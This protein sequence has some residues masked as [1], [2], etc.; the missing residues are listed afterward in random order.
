MVVKT[1]IIYLQKDKFQIFSPNLGSIVEFRF[2]P[3]IVRDLDIINSTLLENLI[4][5][6]VTN[7][8]IAPSN[9]V[10][11][12][13]DNAYFIKDIFATSPEQKTPKTTNSLA[14]ANE[15]LQKQADEFIEHVPFDNVV[16]KTLPLKNGIK[17]CAT[18]KDFYEAFV[19]A[20]EHL[21]FTTESVIPGLVLGNGLSA[22]P[23]LDQGI[24]NL[25]VQRANT[26]KQY[27]LLH[28]QVFQPPAKLETEDTDEVELD[29][30][31]TKKPDKKRLVALTGIFGSLLFVLVIVYVQSQA[32]VTP[33]QQP[34]QASNPP[35]T[36]LP[37]INQVVVS[38]TTAPVVSPSD[39]QTQALTVQIVNAASTSVAAKN[40]SE[41]LSQYTFKNILLQTQSPV[42]SAATIVSF[43]PNVTQ[44]VRNLILDE[45]KKVKSNITVQEKGTA[46]TDITIVLGE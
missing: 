16:S 34:A 6:F 42:G 19:I 30:Q 20:F 45:V 13:A 22:R 2:V 5:V 43:S 23:V 38:P 24:V 10:F 17:V 33:P 37:P 12:L 41:R 31:Q 15:V 26:Y 1:G 46:T 18:N 14:V 44:P 25:I 39:L 27:D 35:P 11:V 36:I 7:G 21:G 32:P 40:L 29:R 4:K 28:Q 8:K 3:E 9:L